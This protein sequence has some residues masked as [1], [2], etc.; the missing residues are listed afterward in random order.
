MAKIGDGIARV[1]GLPDCQM[2]ELLEFPGS[3][4]FGLALNLEEDSIGAV[5]IGVLQ[6]GLVILNVDSIWQFIV[7]G[8]VIIIAVLVNQAQAAL[9][10]LRTTNG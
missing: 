8:V 1:Y 7:V 4:V 6:T 3:G 2:G 5:I 9:E 10:R